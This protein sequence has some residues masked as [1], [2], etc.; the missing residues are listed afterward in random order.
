MSGHA[1][2]PSQVIVEPRKPG[3][4]ITGS[5]CGC[6]SQPIRDG[7]P[8][9]PITLERSCHASMKRSVS[10]GF[11]SAWSSSSSC[12]I[13]PHA[14]ERSGMQPVRSSPLPVLEKRSSGVLQAPSSTAAPLAR[15][16]E[17]PVSAPPAIVV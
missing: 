8:G 2:S 10:P 13:T 1:S 17:K 6:T 9:P 7:G 12:S 5:V 11:R 3:T 4:K 14:D 16:P 15:S